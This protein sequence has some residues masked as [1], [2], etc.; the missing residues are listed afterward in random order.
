MMMQNPTRLKSATHPHLNPTASFGSHRID[1]LLHGTN[2]TWDTGF[3][4]FDVRIANEKQRAP[5]DE[6]RN[7]KARGGWSISNWFAAGLSMLPW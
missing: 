6:S 3:V 5:D 2:N 4:L 1:S 7:K